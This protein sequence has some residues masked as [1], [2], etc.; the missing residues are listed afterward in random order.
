M[1]SLAV[2]ASLLALATVA[3]STQPKKPTAKREPDP[4]AHWQGTSSGNDPSVKLTAI[5]C[6]A[7]DG[8]I[9][10]TLVW[11]SARSGTNT[12]TVDG[13]QSGRS[14]TLRDLTLE[15]NPKPGWRFCKID[16]YALALVGDGD[17]SLEGT[18]HSSACNDDA[19]VK[20]TRIR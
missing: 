17:T 6:P 13:T 4:C 8:R 12:R 5:L 14:L 10:G 16:R 20:L 9:T 3:M 11:E 19:T 15:G 18:Y 1:P 7:G 2:A